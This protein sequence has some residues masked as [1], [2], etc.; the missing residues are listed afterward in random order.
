MS[1][2]E[3]LPN[4]VKPTITEKDFRV[5][6]G[7]PLDKSGRGA[8]S[9]VLIRENPQANGSNPIEAVQT[10]EQ[11]DNNPVSAGG[12]EGAG[13]TSQSAEVVQ[14]EKIAPA[15]VSEL[16]AQPQAEVVATR[17]R[18]EWQNGR[19]KEKLAW[20]DA[21]EDSASFVEANLSLLPEEMRQSVQEAIQVNKDINQKPVSETGYDP[22]S[23]KYQVKKDDGTIEVKNFAPHNGVVLKA[24]K[25]LAT[26]KEGQVNEQAQKEANNHWTK[27]K[28][29]VLFYKDG[30][31]LYDSEIVDKSQDLLTTAGFLFKKLL[32]LSKS[33]EY[34]KNPKLMTE[35]AL[36]TMLI[37]SGDV[38]VSN[39]MKIE[40]VCQILERL[41]QFEDSSGRENQSDL[42][43]I[44]FTEVKKDRYG[45]EIST[46]RVIGEEVAKLRVKNR[47]NI[48]QKG[49]NIGANWIIK[50][51]IDRSIQYN[52]QAVAGNEQKVIAD[53]LN[54]GQTQ[55][56][57]VL[58]ELE[59]ASLNVK[60][61]DENFLAK[62]RNKL[63]GVSINNPVLKAVLQSDQSQVT[64]LGKKLFGFEGGTGNQM[65]EYFAKVTGL[66][67]DNLAKALGKDGMDVSMMKML[68]KYGPW[69][70]LS[71]GIIA[72]MTGE[73]EEE[74]R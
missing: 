3:S 68:E 65:L 12:S 10:I 20:D 45:A 34:Q 40:V 52:G 69:I 39:E 2:G 42:L 72:P 28:D 14:G 19:S 18:Y 26:N 4:I 32:E 49:E 71:Y 15:E 46:N 58:V 27:F 24:V 33:R 1:E 53:L 59:N 16:P 30:A 25:Y 22:D 38:D 36:G 60:L 31:R 6:S 54:N 47:E 11:V 57:D 51:M 55:I 44:S 74:E 73:G 35:I 70:L 62:I 61:G 67:K 43:N 48:N 17:T 66:S 64:A 7:N 8:A 5:S 29:R 23:G 50:Q 63:G 13:D 9:G 41:Q 21:F 37:A 56:V